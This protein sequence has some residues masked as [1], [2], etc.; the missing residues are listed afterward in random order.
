MITNNHELSPLLLMMSDPQ[1]G[2]ITRSIS[3]IVYSYHEFRYFYIFGNLLSKKGRILLG[4]INNTANGNNQ[5]RA[6]DKKSLS[7][8]EYHL[9]SLA[10]T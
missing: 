8:K 4:T 9:F 6:T 2:E 3:E 1:Q 5:A 10:A 7:R